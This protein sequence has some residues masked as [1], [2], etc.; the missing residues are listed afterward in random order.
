MEPMSARL[1]LAVPVYNGLRTGITD[2]V[3]TLLRDDFGDL[4]VVVSDN[5]STDGTWEALN[6]LSPRDPRLRL[7]RFEENQGLVANYNYLLDTAETSLFKWC[8]AGDVV[9]PGFLTA[10]VDAVVSHP[11]T[12]LAHC[13]Y[14]FTD[15][16]RFF[17]STPDW[18]RVFDPAVIP[19]TQSSLAVRRVRGC[20]DHHGYGGHLY[21]V[22]RTDVLQRCG[23]HPDRSEGDRILLAR[24]AAQGR[25]HWD[26]RML[27][28]CYV[29]DQAVPMSDYAFSTDVEGSI[30][31]HVLVGGW[32]RP[33]PVA[34]RLP[35]A[36]WL[37]GR[38]L[39]RK[40]KRGQAGER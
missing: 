18:R 37:G 30:E 17:G 38:I 29:P 27:W 25:F 5:G 40:V 28:S 21:G 11:D 7:H 31:R 32:L 8:A 23:G 6:E 26:E 13:P 24:V 35:V 16:T 10:M 12:V 36:A 15:G 3:Q 14:D 22:I 33:V 4:R 9:R 19:T 39:W 2:L 1:T 20:I 34:Q